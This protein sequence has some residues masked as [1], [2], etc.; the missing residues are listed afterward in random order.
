[1]LS[2]ADDIE[3]RVVALQQET[4]R[5]RQQIS[6]TR[7]RLS[8]R[9]QALSGILDSLGLAKRSRAPP[10]LAALTQAASALEARISASGL[11]LSAL[12]GSADFARA[13]ALESES[14]AP[15]A[16]SERL[17]ECLAEAAEYAAL[18]GRDLKTARG[19]MATSPADVREIQAESARLAQQLGELRTRALSRFDPL[20]EGEREIRARIQSL[21]GSLQLERLS[22]SKALEIQQESARTLLGTASEAATRIRSVITGRRGMA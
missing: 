8:D 18:V 3:R 10:S 14:L 9:Q 16:E 17:T 7:Q 20:L 22:A 12:L 2:L 6:E 19:R 13:S 15:S 5:Y 11:E 4:A 21:E 1:M